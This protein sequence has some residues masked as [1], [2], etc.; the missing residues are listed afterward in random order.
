MAV[1]STVFVM[2]PPPVMVALTTKVRDVP[3]EIPRIACMYQHPGSGELTKNM[4]PIH[5]SPGGFGSAHPWPHICRHMQV[6]AGSVER[7]S[8][9]PVAGF[10]PQVSDSATCMQ[11]EPIAR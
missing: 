10:A 6:G 8:R 1:T 11:A 7:A 5:T 9:Q 2:L 4:H 3:S